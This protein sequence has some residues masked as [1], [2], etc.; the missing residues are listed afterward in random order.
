MNDYDNDNEISSD[1][2]NDTNDNETDDSMIGY[3]EEYNENEYEE[4]DYELSNDN[5]DDTLIQN[6]D[7][8]ER[9]VRSTASK[10]PNRYKPTIDSRKRHD[11]S[12][13]D[14]KERQQFLQTKLHHQLYMKKCERLPKKK[15]KENQHPCT[16]F[17]TAVDVMFTQM[18]AKQGIKL[19]GEKAIAAMYKELKQLDEGA[20]PGKPVVQP[21][22][23][24][25][26]SDKDKK[27][28]L[29]AVNLIKQKRCGK[30]KGRTCADGSKQRATLPEGETVYSPTVST[31]GLLTTMMIAAHEKRDTATFDVPGAFL[32]AEMPKDKQ[33][34]LKLTGEFVD[35]MCDVNEEHKP[36]VIYEKGKKVLY[37]WVTRA[38]YGCIES[39]LLW[40]NLYADTLKDMGFKLNPYDR[41]IANKNINGKQCTIAWYVDDNF[42]SHA[43]SKVVDDIIKIMCEKFGDLTVTRG[44]KHTFLGINFE[45]MDNG[46]LQIHMIDQ[47]KEAIELFGE[48]VE[49]VVSLSAAKGLRDV[50]EESPL[51]DVNKAMTFHSVT[52]KLLFITKRARP[53]IEPT[54]Q[55]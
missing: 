16:M 52:A 1:E 50:D 23:V 40:Y 36:N 31:E 38:I 20:M 6:N 47:L 17:H 11:D 8:N 26:L 25:Q 5:D 13:L 42:V 54:V 12:N 33:V 32:Q 34:L 15:V 22:D 4:N 3:D 48:N 2:S 45:F 35:I 30:I 19:F 14:E 21:I 53:D 28:A 24:K 39:A 51:L 49:G 37:M 55:L 10:A 46:K 41:C 9:P 29:Y 7:D 27:N 43:D 44:N 18:S